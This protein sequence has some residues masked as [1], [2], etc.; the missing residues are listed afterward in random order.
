MCKWRTI[1]LFGIRRFLMENRFE[2]DKQVIVVLSFFINSQKQENRLRYC[3]GCHYR[4]NSAIVTFVNGASNFVYGAFV[5]IN[6]AFNFVNGAPIF[7]IIFFYGAS[8][9]VNMV[10]ISY[11][12]MVPLFLFMVPLFLLNWC[13]YLSIWYLYFCLWCLCSHIC[14]L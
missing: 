1:I 2:N 6:G 9:C 7:F 8:Y 5:F 12:Y 3:M 10:P 14:C 13:L 4:Q 11:K